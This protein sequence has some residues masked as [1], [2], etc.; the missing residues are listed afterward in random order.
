MN[1]LSPK[2]IVTSLFLFVM[3]GFLEIGGGYLIWL[4]LRHDL[5]IQLGEMKI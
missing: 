5:T 2:N 1:N 3:A 4:W